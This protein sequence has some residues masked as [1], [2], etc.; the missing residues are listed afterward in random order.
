MAKEFKQY[1]VNIGII[2]KNDPIKAHH[3]MG[4]V[5]RYYGFLQQV[6]SI[7]TT[8]IPGI[9]SDLAFQMSFKPFN[10]LIGPNGLVATLLVFGT[11]PRMTKLDAL[12]PSIPQRAIA[13]KQAIDEIWKCT[14]SREVNNAFNTYNRLFTVFVHDLLINLPV[15][16]YSKENANQSQE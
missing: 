13:I 15:L 11:Y 6:Y 14:R 2:I 3:F 9:K 1:I 16:V 7:I 10:N 12:S 8:K 5:E 4:M